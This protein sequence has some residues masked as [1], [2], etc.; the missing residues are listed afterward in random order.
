MA[1]IRGS[2]Q[3]LTFIEFACAINIGRYLFLFLTY[4][5]EFMF[6]SSTMRQK[7]LAGLNEP[8]I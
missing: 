7:R 8:K 3:N 2:L 6:C 4:M 1:P 5:D